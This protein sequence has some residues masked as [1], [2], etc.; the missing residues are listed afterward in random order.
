MQVS[1]RIFNLETETAFPINSNIYIMPNMRKIFKFESGL[2]DH[3]IGLGVNAGHDLNLFNLNQFLTKCEI[4][5][6]SIGH[7]LISDALKYGM[8]ETVA[9]YLRECK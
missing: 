3:K 8:Q 1:K 9:K 5:E 7:A 6:V 2:S 4:D